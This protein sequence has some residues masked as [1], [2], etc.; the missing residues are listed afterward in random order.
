MAT[1]RVAHPRIV[2]VIAAVA[3][4]TGCLYGPPYDQILTGDEELLEYARE[5]FTDAGD[6][7]A[8]AVIDGDE[9]RTAFV[10]A[11]SSTMF[12]LGSATRLLTGLLLADA[13]ERREVALDDEVGRYLPLGESPAAELTL[14][15]LAT[16]H[17]G[18]P[19]PPR[20]R[21]GGSS[22]PE[23]DEQTSVELEELLEL[24]ASLPVDDEQRYDFNDVQA[25]L[26]G[27]AVAEATSRDF[28]DLLEER[29][30]EPIGMDD[31]VLAESADD[32]PEALA[33]GRT[34]VTKEAVESTDAGA[35]TPAVGAIVTLDDM[36]ALARGVM[37]GAMSDSAALRPIADTPWASEGIGYFWEREPRPEGDLTS[38]FGWSEGFCAAMVAYADD[39]QAAMVLRNLGE[40]YPW[41]EAVALLEIVRE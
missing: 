2:L 20:W 16:Q 24:V 30:L 23:P 38:L 4:M 3:A 31:T 5:T 26:V 19:V 9:V 22:S 18:L 28:A 37:S 8:M 32:I 1:R 33:Q 34:D 21:A 11:D 36:I 27:H 7:V 12:E 40:T 10:S 6:R 29:V 15:A 41:D 39:G 13:I 35:Y 17:S 25:A 14:R